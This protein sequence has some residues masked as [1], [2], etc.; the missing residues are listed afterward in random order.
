MSLLNK[1]TTQ[2]LYVVFI[3]AL[4]GLGVSS[5]LAY[6]YNLT[7]PVGC[8]IGGSGCETVRLSPFS[9][10]F[11]ISV[12]LLGV[13]FY[14]ITAVLIIIMLDQKKTL[15]HQLLLIWSGGGFLFSVYLTLLEA[16]AIKAYC[17]WCLTSAIIATAIFV[18]CLQR[19]R[20]KGQK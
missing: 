12:P 7:G 20:L 4:L 17:F 10:F 16:F 15:F 9:T 3:L 13:A 14:L 18:F 2:S 11:G 5:Y 1:I 19:S 8:P 6:E